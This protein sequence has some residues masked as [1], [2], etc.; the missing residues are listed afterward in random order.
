MAGEILKAPMDLLL[1]R[2]YDAPSV[3][4]AGQTEGSG[5]GTI[6]TLGP[7]QIQN[8]MAQDGGWGGVSYPTP[9]SSGEAGTKV[10]ND[11]SVDL[12]TGQNS[13][14]MGGKKSK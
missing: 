4:N 13:C 2:D 1:P 14:W 8:N 12:V 6:N 3:G 5:K 11:N 10:S 7:G 9:T